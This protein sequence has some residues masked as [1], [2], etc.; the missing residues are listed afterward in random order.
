MSSVVRTPG[1]VKQYLGHQRSVGQEI[2]QPIAEA[3]SQAIEA[4][5]LKAQLID[6][7]EDEDLEDW[8]LGIRLN[9]KKKQW[10]KE[11]LH[12]LHNLAKEHKTDFV[13]G[14]IDADTREEEDIC[15]FGHEEGKPDLFEI[16]CYIGL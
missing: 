9:I 11:P 13:L 4:K 8:K 14:I 3:M 7:R 2:A 10:L 12:F 15:Y 1:T 5:T 6:Q 16:A